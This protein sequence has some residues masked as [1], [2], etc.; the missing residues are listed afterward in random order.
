MEKR[1][2]HSFVLL[3]ILLV[4]GAFIFSYASFKLTGFAISPNECDGNW[5][6]SNGDCIDGTQTVTWTSSDTTTCTSPVTE[7]QSCEVIVPETNSTNNQTEQNQ[8][9][10][11][12][13]QTTSCGDG[14]VQTPNTLGVDE[15]C[16]N[17]AT[18]GQTCTASYG[19]SCNYCSSTCQTMT[20]QGAS[21]GDG[22][23]GDEETCSTCESDCG[24]CT[25]ENSTDNST[26]DD[27]LSTLTTETITCTPSW[28]CGD[29]QECI[30]GT[31]IRVCT[32]LNNCGSGEIPP[33]SQSCTVIE[34]VSTSNQTVQNKSSFFGLVG[35]VI[36][37]S[38]EGMFGSPARTLASTGVFILIIGGF[39]AFRFFYKRKTIDNS[40]PAQPQAT[41]ENEDENDA[42]VDYSKFERY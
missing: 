37:G 41:G 16:D 19:G 11:Q 15:S 24:V 32:D 13:Q 34:N 20:V 3:G 28:E 40:V 21:C 6:S 8:T 5:T 23:C 10:N 26:E 42:P 18:N 27:S 1:L 25:T 17:G 2:I 12:T 39:V 14:I 7:S 22:T 29:W 33:T 9:E 36:S 35:N 31:Q 38:F 30:G 4:T